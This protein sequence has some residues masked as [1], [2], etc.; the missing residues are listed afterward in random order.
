MVV[1]S[2][3]PTKAHQVPRYGLGW[4]QEAKLI[5]KGVTRKTAGRSCSRLWKCGNQVISY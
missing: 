4:D 5:K 1:K 2:K 3:E